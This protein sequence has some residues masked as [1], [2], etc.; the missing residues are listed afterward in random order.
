MDHRGL[1][2]ARITGDEH[3][4]RRPI[5]DDSIEGREQSVD[6]RLPPIQLLGDQ[7]SVRRVMRTQPESIDAALRL[8][9]S[10]AAPQI[11]FHASGRLIALLSVLG[12]E[13]HSEER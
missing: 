3:E 6:L 13:P 7:Q 12:E 5:V 4:R 2:N 1:A 8:Q 10:Q 9:L 11:R